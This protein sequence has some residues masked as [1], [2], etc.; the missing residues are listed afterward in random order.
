MHFI[1]RYR[2][3]SL[4]TFLFVAC[5]RH[6][7]PAMPKPAVAE[8]T[9]LPLSNPTCIIHDTEQSSGPVLLHVDGKPFALV[10]RSDEIELRIEGS[11]ATASL[12]SFGLNHSGRGVKLT[13]EVKLA[14]LSLS[15]KDDTLIDNWIRL[16]RAAPTSAAVGMLTFSLYPPKEV[17]PTNWPATASL[18]CERLSMG[19]YGPSGLDGYV[20][21]NGAPMYASVGGEQIAIVNTGGSS[22]PVVLLRRDAA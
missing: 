17:Q 3:S 20:N 13:G 21:F 4:S 5:N 12:T 1:K 22:K 19:R 7:S 8:R 2:C 10:P 11:K 18:S 6:G 15:Q 14:E 9:M 16:G